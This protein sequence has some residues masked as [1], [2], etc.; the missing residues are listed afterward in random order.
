MAICTA[1]ININKALRVNIG[2]GLAM[3]LDNTGD[4]YCLKEQ[5]LLQ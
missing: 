4:Q 1:C 5:V 2:G 3:L